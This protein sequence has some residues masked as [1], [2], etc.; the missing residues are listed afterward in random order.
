[1]KVEETTLADFDALL[2]NAVEEIEAAGAPLQHVTLVTGAKYYG[3]HLGPSAAP[4]AETEPR[5]L[6]PNYYYAQEDYLRSRSDA[7]W[8][9]THLI[10]THVTGFLITGAKKEGSS[11]PVG[12]DKLAVTKPTLLPRVRCGWRLRS[13]SVSAV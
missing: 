8:R 4:A 12:L 1:M 2:V 3:V 6:G 13:G 5:H 7:A 11:G 9:W 10:P